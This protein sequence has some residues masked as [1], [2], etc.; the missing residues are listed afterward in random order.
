MMHKQL[1]DY[2]HE[3]KPCRKK[4]FILFLLAMKTKVHGAIYQ[5]SDVLAFLKMK[6]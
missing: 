1:L 3:H 5:L 4:D 6:T 2:K